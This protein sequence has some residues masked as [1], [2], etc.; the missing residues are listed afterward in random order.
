MRV[1]SSITVA[2][3][4]PDQPQRH[5]RHQIPH[6]V[7][8]RR[9][10]LVRDGRDGGHRAALRDD[11]RLR[12]DAR[13]LRGRGHRLHGDRGGR[14]RPRARGRG[15]G[16]PV[17]RLVN[18]ILLNAINKGASDIHIEPY[19]KTL[20]VRYRVDGV[21]VP[22]MQAAAQAQKSPSEPREDHGLARHRRAPA[23]ARRTYQAQ[24]G[25]RIARWTSAFRSCPRSSARRSFCASWTRATC[26]S[27]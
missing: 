23:A 7:Q 20:R 5:R 9:S 11:G 26:S 13:R 19:E 14:Q 27:T 16:A 24:A 17:V 4:D 6:R 8:R 2:M 12:G 22:E 21:L 18:A 10:G 25:R 3:A 15:Q 1:S